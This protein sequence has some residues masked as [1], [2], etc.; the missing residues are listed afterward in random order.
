M[1]AIKAAEH[2]F[3][4]IESDLQGFSRKT[5]QRHF[6]INLLFYLLILNLLYSVQLPIPN[7]VSLGNVITIDLVLPLAGLDVLQQFVKHCYCLRYIAQQFFSLGFDGGSQE[8]ELADACILPLLG[9][10]QAFNLPHSL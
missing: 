1:E 7:T 9:A 6:G 2:S 5:L 8:G 10:G 3:L 4:N